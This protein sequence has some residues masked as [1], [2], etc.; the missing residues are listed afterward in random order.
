MIQET[1]AIPVGKDDLVHDI[2]PQH[3][4]HFHLDAGL[5]PSFP[6]HRV[7]RVLSRFDDPG[8]RSPVAIIGA[9]AEQH[10]RPSLSFPQYHQIGSTQPQGFIPDVAAQLE[11]ELR[12]RHGSILGSGAEVAPGYGGQAQVHGCQ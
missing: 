10:L 9:A 2:Q 1:A 4:L 3:P 11:D 8:D 5:L 12:C 6:R 7:G